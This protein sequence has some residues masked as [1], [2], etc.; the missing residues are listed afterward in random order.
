VEQVLDISEGGLDLNDKEDPCCR[1][2]RQDI[3]RA[4]VA[5]VI[6]TELWQY[7]P[8]ETLEC[9]DHQ[10]DDGGVGAV[11]Q[12]VTLPASPCGVERDR[13][14]KL[15]R[16]TPEGVQANRIEAPTLELRYDALTYAGFCRDIGLAKLAPLSDRTQDATD[17]T[18]IHPRMV[19]SVAQFAV[20][21]RFTVSSAQ[22]V[23]SQLSGS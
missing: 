12:P 4:A 22:P 1:V 2:P 9:L 17:S 21:E 8:I 20:T 23:C 10:L 7:F 13:D 16:D 18:I 14:I 15:D 11:E 19:P 6:E 5:E 3:H